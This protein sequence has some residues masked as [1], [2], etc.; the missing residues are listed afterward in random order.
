[1]KYDNF[2]D[3]LVLTIEASAVFAEESRMKRNN[4]RRF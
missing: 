3:A 1:M 2:V 4:V